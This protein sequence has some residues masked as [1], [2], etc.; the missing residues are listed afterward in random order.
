MG[1][2]KVGVNVDCYN[3]KNYNEPVKLIIFDHLDSSNIITPS[4]FLILLDEQLK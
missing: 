4:A 2:H 3:K 1:V